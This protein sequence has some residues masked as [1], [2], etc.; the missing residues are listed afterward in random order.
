M[1]D[2]KPPV[3]ITKGKCNMSLSIQYKVGVKTSPGFLKE[4]EWA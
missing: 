4:E 1:S 2:L 3:P